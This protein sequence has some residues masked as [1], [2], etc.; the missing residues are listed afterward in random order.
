MKLGHHQLFFERIALNII[1]SPK[2]SFYT[3]ISAACQRKDGSQEAM[4]SGRSESMEDF[5]FL[6]ALPHFCSS[7]L[8]KLEAH[9][10]IMSSAPGHQP[11]SSIKELRRHNPSSLIDDHP[12]L[13]Q[14][15]SLHGEAA[16]ISA[17]PSVGADCPV[18]GDHDRKR[19]CRQGVAHCPGTTGSA[20]MGRDPTVRAHQT[21]RDAIFRQK[22][23]LLKGGTEIEPH[24][25]ERKTDIGSIEER[26]DPPGQ[27]ADEAA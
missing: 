3:K 24:R 4:K 26:R 8:R 7:D 13:F 10:A 16:L 9:K 1:L 6:S 5:F 14:K 27:I 18:A 22:D 23:S 19:I 17:E 20:Q 15:N 12:L 25:L 21:P 2:A 11:A